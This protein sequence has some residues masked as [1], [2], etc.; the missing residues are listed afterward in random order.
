[1]LFTDYLLYLLDYRKMKQFKAICKQSFRSIYIRIKKDQE[2][3]C[4]HE[5]TPYGRFTYIYVDDNDNNRYAY[6]S[7]KEFDIYFKSLNQIRKEK[8]DKLNSL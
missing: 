7:A 5:I 6:I 2:Y 4:E 1:L 3:T 8:L